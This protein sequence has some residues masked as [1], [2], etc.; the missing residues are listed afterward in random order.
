LDVI[1]FV[2]LEPFLKNKQQQLLLN[3]IPPKY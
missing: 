2:T 3:I 1:K